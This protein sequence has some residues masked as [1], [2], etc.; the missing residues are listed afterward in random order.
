VN[1]SR[2]P[3]RDAA[4]HS[5]SGRMASPYPVGDFHL[6]FFA[7]FPGALRIRSL[8]SLL[9]RSSHVCSSPDS[10]GIAS[11]NRCL[12]PEAG[13]GPERRPL[14]RCG[15]SCIRRSDGRAVERGER[16]HFI[17]RELLGDYAHLLEDVILSHSLRERREVPLDI[18][19]MLSLQ[20]G[21]TE[22][23]P[24]DRISLTLTK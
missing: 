8:A 20:G 12:G 16:V 6:L 21:R 7:S 24:S 1:A 23:V 5:G 11:P 3:S 17:L 9:A 4:H 22:L 10:G 19:R 2:R 15:T 14:P 18:G 13:I